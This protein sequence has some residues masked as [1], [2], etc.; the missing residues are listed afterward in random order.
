M[1]PRNG[2]PGTFSKCVDFF[3]KDLQRQLAVEFQKHLLPGMYRVNIKDPVCINRLAMPPFY[4]AAFAQK[5][6][7]PSDGI[8]RRRYG[9]GHGTHFPEQ[10]LYGSL[11]VEQNFFSI[12]KGHARRTAKGDA[13]FAGSQPCSAA[14]G[15]NTDAAG[16]AV[17]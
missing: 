3:C 14:A 8:F 7:C 4:R 2:D 10:F 17:D 5:P 11:V 16:D 6:Q 9:E 13:V 15:R 1:D 12:R